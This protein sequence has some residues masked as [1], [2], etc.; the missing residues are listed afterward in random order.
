MKKYIE[1]V[2]DQVALYDITGAENNGELQELIG[3]MLGASATP[4][5]CGR[6]AS[7]G[8]VD[9]VEM[10]VEELRG[11]GLTPL[12]ALELKAAFR[13]AQKLK[14]V[15]IAE[16]R[17][18]IRTPD[19]AA[20]FL[21][22]EMRG[23]KQEHFVMLMLNTKNEVIGKKTMFI[24]T[25]NSS[26]VHPREIMREAIKKSSASIMVFHNHPSG[27]PKESHQD[28]EVTKRIREASMIVGCELLDHIIIGDGKYVSLKE[29]GFI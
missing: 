27:S 26:L 1:T 16:K 8:I 7:Y 14:R 10:T 17:Y 3:V 22:S 15:G 25:L 9:L 21:M 29:K 5:L 23:L 18:I 6:L 11:H 20:D 24:G 2:R 19:D 12:K 4:E 13:L 28:I